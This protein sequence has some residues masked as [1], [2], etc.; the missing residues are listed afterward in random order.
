MLER[1]GNKRHTDLKGKNKTVP[2]CRW[3]D[4]LWRIPKV[5]PKNLEL[6]SEL[7]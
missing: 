6:I 5:L 2:I 7:N 1:K 4:S 3:H